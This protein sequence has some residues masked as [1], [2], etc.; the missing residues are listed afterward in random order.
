MAFNEA[1]RELVQFRTQWPWLDAAIYVSGLVLLALIVNFIVK[2]LLLRGFDRLIARTP[3][4]RDPEL[5]R[6]G[7]VERLAMAAP[8]I[9]IASGIGLTPHVP[10]TASTNT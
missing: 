9:V 4:G 8:A 3:W 7:V 5:R 1:L 6:H 10:P 2:R